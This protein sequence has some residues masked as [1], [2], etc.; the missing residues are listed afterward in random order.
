MG[1]TWSCY[2][3]LK[4]QMREDKGK[5]PQNLQSLGGCLGGGLALKW[6]PQVGKGGG[7][8]EKEFPALLLNPRPPRLESGEPWTTTKVVT[9]QVGLSPIDRVEVF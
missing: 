5:K 2:L 3:S 8:R 1:S 9:S 4:R 7:R 6:L